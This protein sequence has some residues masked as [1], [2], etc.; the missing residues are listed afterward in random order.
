MHRDKKAKLISADTALFG[1]KGRL[2][3]KYLVLVWFWQDLFT[4]MSSEWLSASPVLAVFREFLG[5]S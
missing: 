2:V 1:I 4:R 3:G 5:T